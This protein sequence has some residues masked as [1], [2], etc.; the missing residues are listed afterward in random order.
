MYRGNEMMAAFARSQ[1]SR[2]PENTAR[3]QSN[4]ERLTRALEDLPGVLLPRVPAGRTSVHHK[5]RVRLS[6]DRAGVELPAGMFREVVA[7]ALRAEGLDVVRWQADVL[8]AHPIF[9]AREGFGDGWPWSTD[10]E[11]D[12]ATLYDPARFPG[13]KR[14]LDN[15]IVLFS[16]SCPL[17]AQTDETVDRY[18]EAFRRVWEVRAELAGWAA[19]E[20]L[21]EQA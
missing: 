9:R 11:T 15:S 3:C 17:I 16:Q 8:P 14:L 13:A 1:L 2:L 18:A 6:A 7:R 19:R 21:S 12:F 4:A 5:F 20:A 10:R